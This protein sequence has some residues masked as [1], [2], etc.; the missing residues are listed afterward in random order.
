VLTT[1][2]DNH[3]E[4]TNTEMPQHLRSC[5]RDSVL[6]TIRSQE[7]SVGNYAIALDL[8]Q[9]RFDTRRLVFQAYIT[10]ILGLKAV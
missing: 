2:I 9:N 1:I 3:P 6:D 4:L 7:I 8:L 10:E 5:L